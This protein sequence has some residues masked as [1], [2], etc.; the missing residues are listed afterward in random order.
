V[1]TSKMSAPRAPARTTVRVACCTASISYHTTAVTAHRSCPIAD[2][3]LTGECLERLEITAVGCRV[4]ALGRAAH[5]GQGRLIHEFG[6]SP[7]TER[8]KSSHRRVK[9][10]VHIPLASRVPGLM[11]NEDTILAVTA[12]GNSTTPCHWLRLS[13]PLKPAGGCAGGGSASANYVVLA[14][15]PLRRTY[16]G[17]SAAASARRRGFVR[18]IGGRY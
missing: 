5:R 17:P 6:R 10:G 15:V 1:A 8:V 18:S 2:R 7:P 4:I 16:A 9:V 14:Q 13:T 12:L 3:G 11:A